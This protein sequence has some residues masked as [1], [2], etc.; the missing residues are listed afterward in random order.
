M[1]KVKKRKKKWDWPWN[2]RGELACKH[3]IGHGGI[4]GCDGCC[5]NDRDGFDAGRLRALEQGKWMKEGE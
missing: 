5:W 3:G 1:G 2:G 4:H